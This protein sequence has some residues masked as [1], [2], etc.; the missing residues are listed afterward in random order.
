M[1]EVRVEIDKSIF[2]LHVSVFFKKTHIFDTHF[3]LNHKQHKVNHHFKE[4]IFDWLWDASVILQISIV[5]DSDWS[6]TIKKI[7]TFSARLDGNIA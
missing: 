7:V 5:S 1:Q 4:W 6:G 3:Q 2:V